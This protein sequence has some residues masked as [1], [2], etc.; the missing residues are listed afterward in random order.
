MTYN[1]KQKNEIMLYADDYTI[2]VGVSSEGSNGFEVRGDLT[3]DEY[4][5]YHPN[6]VSIKSYETDKIKD[7]MQAMFNKLKDNAPKIIEM[8]K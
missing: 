6:A 2:W 4:G 3:T 5:Q 8:L 7:T 1:N